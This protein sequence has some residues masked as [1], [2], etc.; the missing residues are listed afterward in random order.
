M[1]GE[2]CPA[3]M[4]GCGTACTK[5]VQV[6]RAKEEGSELAAIDSISLLAAGSRSNNVALRRRSWAMVSLFLEVCPR[7]E[8]QQD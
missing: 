5:A 2:E 4:S 7:G 3:G 8:Q 6:A 1:T